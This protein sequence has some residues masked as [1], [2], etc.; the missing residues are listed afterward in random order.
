MAGRCIFHTE[1][2]EKDAS[3]CYFLF[4]IS[5]LIT[6]FLQMVD[7]EEPLYRYVTAAVSY[8]FLKQSA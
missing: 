7:W 1:E 5:R 2:E 6:K 3:K 8:A 4:S